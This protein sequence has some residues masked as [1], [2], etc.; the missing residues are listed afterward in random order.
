MADLAIVIPAYKA[1]FF[2]QA[3]E[4]IAAQT[5]RNFVVYVGDDA[6]PHELRPICEVYQ[7]RLTLCYT[8]FER[9]LGQKDLAAHWTRCVALASE[10]WIWLFS[11][12]DV[13]EPGCVAAFHRRRLADAGAH[14]LYHFDVL[15]IDA[16]GAMQREAP[17]FEELTPA[18]DFALARLRGRISSY[19]PDY[20]FA[21]AALQGAGG[22]QA[23]PLAWCSD[24]AT[25]IKLA[26]RGGIRAL[27][28][29]RVRWRRSGQNI[30]SA[31]PL[32]AAR[33]LDA[34]AQF[35][36]WLERY[37]RQHPPLPSEPNRHQLLAQALTW[38][39]GQSRHLLTPF[40]PRGG[41]Q[42]AWQ[43][44]RVVRFGYVGGLAKTAYWDLRYR[45]RGW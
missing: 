38:L 36:G 42:A 18:L 27:R 41:F 45:L 4:S 28:G 17:P 25:W 32:L 3:L 29:A 9:N 16:Q 6:S 5:D 22:F 15:E 19:A 21:L 24:D 12:D 14:D 44:R 33:K 39:C 11:D 35:V 1:A 37:L 26:R 40:W 43:L 31:N 23:F 8:R 34:A 7:Q 20:V 10:P 30:T 13:M 2:H